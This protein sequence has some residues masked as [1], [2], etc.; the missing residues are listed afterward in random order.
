M[1]LILIL[2]LSLNV[3]AEEHEMTAEEFL[4]DI[5]DHI[6]FVPNALKYGEYGALCI[7]TRARPDCGEASC[8]RRPEPELWMPQCYCDKPEGCK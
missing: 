2:L 1:R 4:K 7:P 8:I 3:S 6:T 5:D